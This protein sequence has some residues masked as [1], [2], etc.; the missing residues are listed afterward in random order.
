ML[1][2]VIVNLL[3]NA[4]DAGARGGHVEASVTGEGAEVVFTVEDDGRGITP[5]EAARATEPFFTTKGPDQGSGLGLAIAN[6]I[7]KLHRGRL[8][9]VP[10]PS[11]GTRVTVVV[12]VAPGEPSRAAPTSLAQGL[13]GVE[14]K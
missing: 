6:E 10:A 9:I 7:V 3:L 12:P 1:Q 14:T 8:E 2:Q 13:A 4:C 11:R 5:E